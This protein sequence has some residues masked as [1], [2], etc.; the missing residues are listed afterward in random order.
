MIA[1]P[2]QRHPIELQLCS[3]LFYVCELLFIRKTLSDVQL[4]S[5]IKIR[6][7]AYFLSLF[8]SYR[9]LQND[10]GLC[11]FTDRWR[12]EAAL[13]AWV[14]AFSSNM[15]LNRIALEW[16]VPTHNSQYPC[17]TQGKETF[18]KGF[19]SRS[20]LRVV[21]GCS[22]VRCTGSVIPRNCMVFG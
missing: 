13:I 7:E 17:F 15:S 5:V 21:P 6:Y 16:R 14:I 19:R 1:D 11:C 3:I 9:S 22:S 18:L 4:N 8:A 20:K 2:V 10:N 12:P